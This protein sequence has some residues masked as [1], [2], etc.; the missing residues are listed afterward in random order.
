[1]ALDNAPILGDDPVWK[2]KAEDKIR[3]LE[4][5]VAK[6]EGRLQYVESRLKKK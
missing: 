6:L 2:K 1:M 5:H 4:A 3:K